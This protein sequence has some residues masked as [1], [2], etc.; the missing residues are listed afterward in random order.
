M[1]TLRCTK[2][3]AT[4]L[5]FRLAEEARTGTSPLGDWYV[6][7]IPTAGGGLFLFVNEQSLLAVVVP[8]GEPGL[9]NLF[10]ARVGNILSMVGVPNARIE[11]ELE[12]FA[13]ARSAKTT[14]RRVV[15]LMN[16]LAWRCQREIDEASPKHKL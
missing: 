10:V 6:N 14:S 9:L 8:R 15:A 2:K 3:A 13:E 5:G 1:I 7:L 12:H 4:A 11:Q 16:D